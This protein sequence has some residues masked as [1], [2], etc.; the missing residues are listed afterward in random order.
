MRVCA[1]AVRFALV[2]TLWT[3]CGCSWRTGCAAARVMLLLMTSC[4]S[5]RPGA[6]NT[7]LPGCAAATAAAMLAK[8]CPGPTCSTYRHQMPT[9]M[10]NG[11]KAVCCVP[12]ANE[13]PRT[14][15]ARAGW[16]SLLSD[17]NPA[18]ARS[19]ERRVHVL[20]ICVC[21]LHCK[22]IVAF[23]RKKANSR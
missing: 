22:L 13:P 16:M 2:A 21:M 19:V 4:S 5:Y 7:V 8:G 18:V 9:S 14:S 23:V 15:A 17:S 6:I 20:F 10:P 12:A 1:C 11:L 3:A